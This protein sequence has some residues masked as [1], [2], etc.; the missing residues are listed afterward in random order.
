MCDVK[1]HCKGDGAGYR[2]LSGSL[3][4]PSKPVLTLDTQ[5]GSISHVVIV[6]LG[7]VRCFCMGNALVV[8]L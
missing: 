5:V 2:A 1:A 3:D 6:L 4:K 8:M 7:K